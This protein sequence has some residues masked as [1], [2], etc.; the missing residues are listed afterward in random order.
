[1]ENIPPLLALKLLSELSTA[2]VLLVIFTLV[3]PFI[4]IAVVNVILPI[5]LMWAFVLIALESAEKVETS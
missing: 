2:P 5:T 1:M 4:V 3:F